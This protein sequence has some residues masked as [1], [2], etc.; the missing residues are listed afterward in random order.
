MDETP[1]ES[2]KTRFFRYGLNVYPMYFGTGGR[3]IY[4]AGD[5]T[6]ATVRLKL[7]LFTR[8]YVGT[9]FGGS[10]FAAADPFHMVLLM[11]ILGPQF[12]VWD[13]AGRI[14]FKKPGRGPIEAKF[15]Y[16]PEEITNIRA[17]TVENGSFEFKKSVPWIDEQ[18]ETV[19][20]FE[21]TVYVATKEFFELRQQ[22]KEE[23]AAASKPL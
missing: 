7:N 9:I 11:N 20:I 18:G 23:I 17:A 19:S 15:V 13:K 5:W 2:L 1:K 21:K 10:M 12:I 16:T 14:D 3:L 8:N 6:R 4:L 22:A